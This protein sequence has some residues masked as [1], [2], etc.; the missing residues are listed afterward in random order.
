MPFGFFGID[1]EIRRE[2]KEEE[3]KKITRNEEE[4]ITDNED[5]DEVVIK[6][7][8]VLKDTDDSGYTAPEW[9]VSSKTA[10]PILIIGE[11]IEIARDFLCA[12]HENLNEVLPAGGVTCY[13]NDDYTLMS[14]SQ[15]RQ[16]INISL[17]ADTSVK[18]PVYSD[19]DEDKHYKFSISEAGH[20]QMA[21]DLDFLCTTPGRRG[22]N[23][24]ANAAAAIWIIT[25][26]SAK[27]LNDTEYEI[28]IKE[29]LR[30]LNRD[31]INIEIILSLFES[32]GLFR[33]SGSSAELPPELRQKLFENCRQTYMDALKEAGIQAKVCAVQMYGGLELCGR[34]ES[35]KP[36]YN[37]NIDSRCAGYVPVAC[38]IPV[39]HLFTYLRTLGNGYLC[40]PDGEKIWR[41]VQ[42]AFAPYIGLRQWD[43][44]IID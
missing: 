30:S 22:L 15:V 20:P 35:G 24:I 17:T 6:K 14:L 16:G 31:K 34:D 32:D 38:Q 23:K 1:A 12:M 27:K 8:D 40:E 2:K 44:Y 7:N 11:T 39:L 21:I 36:L 9:H 42:K 18:W 33:N 28:L 5:Q 41:G 26:G 4:E 25:T 43:A 29:F 13:T 3:L 10:V 37:F 19:K